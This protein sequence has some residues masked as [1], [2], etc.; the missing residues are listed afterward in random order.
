MASAGFCGKGRGVDSI[1]LAKE[2]LGD[3]NR[4][5]GRDIKSA[6]NGLDRQ[7]CIQLL[8]GHKQLQ[9]WVAEFL[10]P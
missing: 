3:D 7:I 10:R 2:L 9:T 1:M 4:L 8:D 5:V 6:F